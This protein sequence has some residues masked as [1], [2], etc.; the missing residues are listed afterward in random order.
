ML[1][2]RGTVYVLHDQ[3]DAPP[4]WEMT[5]G[6][7]AEIAATFLGW[8][9]LQAQQDGYKSD[10]ITWVMSDAHYASFDVFDGDDNDHV[11]VLQISIED[12]C[13]EH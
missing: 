4:A 1:D 8:V 6:S 12:C 3:A 9:M 7:I 11:A 2:Y 13:D 5:G 10:Y